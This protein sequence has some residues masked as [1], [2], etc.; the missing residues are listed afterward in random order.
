MI[1]ISVLSVYRFGS[2]SALDVNRVPSGRLPLLSARPAVTFPVA[3]RRRHLT[4]TNCLVAEAYRVAQK[5]GTF[6]ATL[7]VRKR[8]AQ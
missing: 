4:C 3:K 7:Y 8:F 5:I 6:W 2:Q 1:I